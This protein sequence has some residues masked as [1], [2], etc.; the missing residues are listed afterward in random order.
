MSIDEAIEEYLYSMRI[1]RG[2]SRNTIEAYARDL[3]EYRAYLASEGISDADGIDAKDVHGFQAQL[4]SAGY[5]ASSAKRKMSAVKGLHRFLVREDMASS[6]PADAVPLPKV[7]D[8]LP[9]VISI[10]EVTRLLDSLDGQDELSLRD[11]ALM[12]VLYGCGLR[13]SEACG[14]DLAD[15]QLDDG[16]LL[17]RGKGDKERLVPISGEAARCLGE[18]LERARGPLSLRAK[19]PDPKTV[20]AVFLNARGGRL[21]R[22]GLF[23]IVRKAA[24]GCGIDDIHPHT[25]R[26]SFATHMLEGGADLRVIQQILGHSDISTTQIYTHID[27]QHLR[28]EYLYAH[29]RARK[30]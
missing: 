30:A 15:V 29:P 5:A 8:K 7:P 1:E 11:R 22:Q 17:V 16:F 18:Y 14:L 6:S 10:H 24:A 21:T 13:A 26:H 2:A 4:A 27:R 28:E 12:E 23:G 3:E 25:L 19:V 20:G 9:D